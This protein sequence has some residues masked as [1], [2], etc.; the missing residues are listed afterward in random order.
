MFAYTTR[1]AILALVLAAGCQLEHDNPPDEYIVDVKWDSAL[2]QIVIYEGQMCSSCPKPLTPQMIER[3][4][5]PLIGTALKSR[6]QVVPVAGTSSFRIQETDGLGFRDLHLLVLGYR[7]TGDQMTLVSLGTTALSVSSGE[8]AKTKLSLTS[9]KVSA[10]EIWGKKEC[11]ALSG[12]MYV[13]EDDGDCDD[14]IRSQDCNDASYCDP[15]ATGAAAQ[16]ACITT[17][18]KPCLGDIGGGCSLGS[19]VVCRDGAALP[20]TLSCAAGGTCGAAT[21]LPAAACESGCGM[22]G[23]TRTV[24]QCVGD[25]WEFEGGLPCHLPAKPDAGT[26]MVAC[27]EGSAVEVALPF[28]VCADAT[29]LTPATFVSGESLSTTV[30]AGCTLRVEHHGTYPSAKRNVLVR[31]LADGALETVRLVLEANQ[32]T[33]GTTGACDALPPSALCE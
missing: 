21:C 6:R 15:A 20:R 8:T 31:V 26:A 13:A 10:V 19:Q 12:V 17:T 7:R 16:A 11:A 2:D 33:C 23:D 30:T 9:D 22:A 4:T 18:C 29:I 28:A 5:A 24:L 3:G 1:I 27:D 25:E 32:G 14:I